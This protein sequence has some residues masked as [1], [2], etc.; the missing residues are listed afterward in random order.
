MGIVTCDI[1]IS[2]DGYAAGADQTLERPF[3]D[4]D[5]DATLHAWMFDH[6]DDHRDELAAITAAGA[7]IM[8]RNMFGPSRGEWDL[9]WT[10]WWGPD[11]PY[12]APVFVLTHVPRDP[13]E[14][15]GGTTFHFVTDGPAAALAQAREA[16]GER[17][18]AVAGGPSTVN[19]FLAAGLIDE[20]RLH[21]TPVVLDVGYV[22]MFDGVGPISWS[23][24]SARWTPEVTH[25]TY[26]R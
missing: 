25:L 3:G 2:L 15:A 13:V 16:A 18:V 26:R 9:E 19:Q 21:V 24:S 4:V 11:P 7:F 23:S 6:A 8:G 12:H 5:A 1:S 20:L 22:R 10:G 17:D 14:M